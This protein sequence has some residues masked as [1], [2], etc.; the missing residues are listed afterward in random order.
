MILDSH[1]RVMLASSCKKM[2][3]TLTTK[4]LLA[5]FHE[6]IYL[7]MLV[8]GLVTWPWWPAFDNFRHVDG[9]LVKSDAERQR[10]TQCLEVTIEIRVSEVGVLSYIWIWEYV[11]DFYFRQSHYFPKLCISWHQSINIF[12][13]RLI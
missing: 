6:D 11:L 5:N 10:V 8:I 9:S 1:G 3:E 7:L 12:F 13:V 4:S 2:L